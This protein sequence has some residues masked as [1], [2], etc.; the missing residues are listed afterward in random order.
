M[1]AVAIVLVTLAAAAWAASGRRHRHAPAPVR[2]AEPV[3][4][5]HPA[6]SM[7]RLRF[8]RGEITAS[9]YRRV[10]EAMRFG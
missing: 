10:V 6:L 5:T 3:P 2:A 4:A 8:A 7:A 1:D 9:D